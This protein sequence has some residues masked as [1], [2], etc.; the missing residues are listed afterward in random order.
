MTSFS[1][2]NRERRIRKGKIQCDYYAIT[3]LYVYTYIFSRGNK[4]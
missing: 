1:F 3:T 2:K 4:L